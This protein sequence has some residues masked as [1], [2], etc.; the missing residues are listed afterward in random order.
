V[1]E[2]AGQRDRTI[3]VLSSLVEAVAASLDRPP[4]TA[5]IA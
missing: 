4:T 3:P 2:G 1:G 5:R